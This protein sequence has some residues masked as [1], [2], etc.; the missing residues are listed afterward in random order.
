VIELRLSPYHENTKG[1]G[2]EF[3]LRREERAYII[4]GDQTVWKARRLLSFV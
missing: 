1:E 3:R 2:G 4:K